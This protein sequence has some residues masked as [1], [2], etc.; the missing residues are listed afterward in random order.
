MGVL[1]GFFVLL[2]LGYKTIMI[3]VFLTL[4]DWFILLAILSGVPS[5]ILVVHGTVA[6][7]LGQDVWTLPFTM[8]TNFGKAFTPWRFCTSPRSPS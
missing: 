8:I 1:S 6:N 5:S 3:K 2:R 7:G 4:D